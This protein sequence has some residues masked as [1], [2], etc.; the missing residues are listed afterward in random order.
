M[1]EN[2]VEEQEVQQEVSV[3]EQYNQFVKMAAIDIFGKAVVY[4]KTVNDLL[5]DIANE[6][7]NASKMNE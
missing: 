1:E 7:I 5:N 4:K 6:C 2:K 3:E